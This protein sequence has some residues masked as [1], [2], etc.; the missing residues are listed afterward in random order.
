MWSTDL[1]P[2]WCERSRPKI[3]ASD[4]TELAR[5]NWIVIGRS[6]KGCKSTAACWLEKHAK[7]V[8]IAYLSIPGA[9]F[10]KAGD[11]P[12]TGCLRPPK[13]APVAII[14]EATE[15]GSPQP[16]AGAGKSYRRRA[17]RCRPRATVE[18]VRSGVLRD[19][20]VGRV[21]SKAEMS[22]S[23]AAIISI[24]GLRSHLRFSA[25]ISVTVGEADWTDGAEATHSLRR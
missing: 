8:Q 2:G 20:V 10:R 6:T 7:G 23:A 13:A 19:S 15:T 4:R 24:F 21:Q 11:G 3:D 25:P 1:I 14:L 12:P 9:Y 18:G 16:D 22:R 5:S 17:K